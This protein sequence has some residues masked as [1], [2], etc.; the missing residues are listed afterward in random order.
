MPLQH[1]NTLSP[2]QASSP[3]RGQPVAAVSNLKSATV[4]EA[5]CCRRGHRLPFRAYVCSLPET[6]QNSNM[7]HSVTQPC[8]LSHVGRPEGGR[9]GGAPGGGGR[10]R[11]RGGGSGRRRGGPG[12]AHGAAA[13]QLAGRRLRLEPQGDWRKCSW[14]QGLGQT[15]ILVHIGEKPPGTLLSADRP[16]VW[17]LAAWLVA[18]VLCRLSHAGRPQPTTCGCTPS[19]GDTHGDV[20]VS[21]YFRT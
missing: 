12:A 4:G 15:L 19:G 10:R 3:I 18:H 2:A 20:I 8:D 6:S 14:N 7:N 16:S 1:D 11:H 9:A 13:V 5:D 17:R 21:S